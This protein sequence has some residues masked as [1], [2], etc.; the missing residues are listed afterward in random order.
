MSAW[1]TPVLDIPLTNRS[2]ED[3]SAPLATI[4]LRDLSKNA[5]VFPDITPR[6]KALPLKTNACLAS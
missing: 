4:A 5:P 2:R 3:T 1:V 6:K